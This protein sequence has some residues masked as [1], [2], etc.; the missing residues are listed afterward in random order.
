MYVVYCQNKPKSEFIV[1]EYV[2]SYFE[3]IRLKLGEKLKLPDML[4]K[5]VQR[6]MRYQLMLKDIMKYTERA[7]LGD[8]SVAD[9]QKALNCIMGI[10]KLANDFMEVGRLQGFEVLYLI[11]SIL[12]CNIQHWFRINRVN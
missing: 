9:L 1:S 3:E 4:I 5:P 10:C 7:G 6:V 12:I 8:K 11:F 2:D